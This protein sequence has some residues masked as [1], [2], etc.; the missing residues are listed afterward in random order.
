MGKLLLL[1]HLG[2]RYSAILD[3]SANIP[4]LL[5]VEREEMGTTHCEVC[6]WLIR[7]WNHRSLMAD[8]VLYQYEPQERILDAFPLVKILYVANA[9]CHHHSETL[10][11]GVDAAKDVLGF[12]PS[13]VA[14]MT[15]AANQEVADVAQ[16]LDIPTE[17]LAVQELS[18]SEEK[19]GKLKDLLHEVRD[20]S[21]LSGTLQN[22][23]KADSMDTILDVIGQSL[24]ILFHVEKVFFFLYVSAKD[25]LVGISPEKDGHGDPVD[26]LEI[27]VENE[28]SLIA[29][30]LTAR[31]FLDS[32]GDP[33]SGTMTIAEE[34]IVHL[35]GTE[36][37]MCIPM[38]IGDQKV[39]VIV[40]G[41]SESQFRRLTGQVKLLNMFANQVAVSLHVE[42]MKQNRAMLLQSERWDAA[43]TI[44][45]KI[46]HEVNNR[47]GIMK[48]YI[49]IVQMR[50]PEEDSA[51]GELKIVSEE[52]DRV[53]HIADQLSD[54]SQPTAGEARPV[55]LE[56]LFA[57]L[58]KIL[59]IS[60]LQ[61]KK[62]KTH[63]SLDPT[64]PE[65][66]TDQDAL[67]Q[68]FINLIKN[69]AEAMPHG[70]NIYLQTKRVEASG[71]LGMGDKGPHALEI[72]LNDDGPGMPHDIKSKLFEPYNSSKGTDHSGLGL[73]IVH[74]IIEE[75]EGTI[76]CE[77]MEGKGTSFRIVLPLA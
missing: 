13:L 45:R 29:R 17:Q 11:V 55:P 2:E 69:A 34:Q 60:I 8:A 48:N 39:G 33:R 52:I 25:A 57:G 74:N 7:P 42:Q 71:E 3:D 40:V 58:M 4:D 6:A 21:L 22:L 76:S 70:G 5:R 47:L 50:L 44:A 12:S 24:Q 51:L 43:A 49:K 75:L 20:S 26:G 30:S 41:T 46:G 66:V 14:E 32:F 62:I 61:P 63:L 59:D 15:G 53:S 56:H 19:G 68:V 31:M 77:S 35:A 65:I 18:V 23:L 28:R 72:T 37:I 10:V 67:K 36:G 1:V 64:V 9:L 54:F 27:G 16:S 73:S 38:L